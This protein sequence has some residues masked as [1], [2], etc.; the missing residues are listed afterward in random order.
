MWV[1]LINILIS[2]ISPNKATHIK[3]S[4]VLCVPLRGV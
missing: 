1:I 3:N 4:D 2:S